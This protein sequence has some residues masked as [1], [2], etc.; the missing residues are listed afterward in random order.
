MVRR[1]KQDICSAFQKFLSVL[2]TVP[3][4]AKQDQRGL[5]TV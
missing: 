3:S 4:L 5:L 1:R 2:I